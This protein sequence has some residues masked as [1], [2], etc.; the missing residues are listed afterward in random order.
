MLLFTL[1]VN[2]IG[3]LD[4]GSETGQEKVTMA[5]GDY[6]LLG[7]PSEEPRELHLRTF[8]LG[9]ERANCLSPFPRVKSCPDESLTPSHFRAWPS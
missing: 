5:K 3:V 6:S 9:Q 7:L 1:K 8:H 4:R 2:A